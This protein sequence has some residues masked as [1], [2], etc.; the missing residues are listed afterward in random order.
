M[1]LGSKGA[2]RTG[3]DN[4]T[5]EKSPMNTY[6]GETQVNLDC[7]YSKKDIFTYVSPMF[8][9]CF[10]Y[11]SP[12][13]EKHSFSPILLIYLQWYEIERDQQSQFMDEEHIHFHQCLQIYYS[14]VKQKRIIGKRNG[15]LFFTYFQWFKRFTLVQWV[16]INS[17]NSYLFPIL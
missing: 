3:T 15:S 2:M 4:L 1:Y 5:H 16:V 17:Q 11:V 7:T 10:T 9:P 12:M 6:V 13:F 8:H 14:Y